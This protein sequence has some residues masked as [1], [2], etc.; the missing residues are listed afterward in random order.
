MTVVELL[1]NSRCHQLRSLEWLPYN[2]T[3]LKSTPVPNA[4]LMAAA[5]NIWCFINYFVPF[6]ETQSEAQYA[7]GPILLL[8]WHCS[9][10]TLDRKYW[11][12]KIFKASSH[13]WMRW[14]LVAN[15]LYIF[16]Q[17]KILACVGVYE[18]WAGQ[19][20]VSQCKLYRLTIIGR[21]LCKILWNYFTKQWP[22][23]L[24]G[25]KCLQRTKRWWRGVSRC[26]GGQPSGKGQ[27]DWDKSWKRS[28]L[29]SE[30]L[31]QPHIPK[32]VRK[33]VYSQPVEKSWPERACLCSLSSLCSSFQGGPAS[34]SMNTGMLFSP[35]WAWGLLWHCTY[36]QLGN[37]HNEKIFSCIF[38]SHG[39]A[40]GG[41]LTTGLINN[42]F[43]NMKV[44]VLITQ[45]R[46]TVNKLEPNALQ[47]KK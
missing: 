37:P 26:R 10:S 36:N 47:G 31:V 3:L 41:F 43:C 22:P 30:H 12:L 24:T 45:H 16:F 11:M 14:K 23:S 35:A 5:R 40:G 9:M 6:A 44:K 46:L 29:G 19:A 33:L 38:L 20:I 21:D 42:A 27:V 2:G 39:G 8:I 13:L 7:V 25:W 15:H 28:H 17:V 18:A 4:D 1:G 32:A 34:W